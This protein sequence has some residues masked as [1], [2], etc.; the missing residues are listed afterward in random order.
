MIPTHDIHIKWSHPV[1]SGNAFIAGTWSVPGHGPW[2][3][4]PMTRIDGTDSF[5]IH[6]DVQE[7]EDISDYLDEDGYLHHEL[8]DHHH[9]GSSPPL[10]PTSTTSSTTTHLSRRKRLSRFFGRA[11]SP[12][13]AS[14][15]ST[16]STNNK[17]LHIDLP[18]HHQSKDGTVLPLAREYRYQYK[19]VIDDEWK[20]D[21]D[22]AQVQD[23]HGHWNHELVV[24]LVEQLPTGVVGGRSR[25][26]SLQ[27][28]HGPQVSEQAPINK[29]LPVPLPH[30]TITTTSI[31]DSITAI[32]TSIIVSLAE[33]QSEEL[34]REATE[35]VNTVSAPVPASSSTAFTAAAPAAAPAAA[36]VIP[37][38]T[39]TRRDNNV[40]S[41]DTYEAV[42]IFDETDDLSDGEGGHSKR[43]QVVESDDEDEEDMD[44][45]NNISIAIDSNNNNINNN[46][47]NATEANENVLLGEGEDVV[48]AEVTPQQ[49]NHASLSPADQQD[50]YPSK[51]TSSVVIKA[52]AANA[53]DVAAATPVLSSIEAEVSSDKA[54][55][56]AQQA[57]EEKKD[58]EQDVAAA[59][60]DVF[61][62]SSSVAESLPQLGEPSIIILAAPSS[63]VEAEKVA[64]VEKTLEAEE[65]PAPSS[66]VSS[67]PAPASVAIPA[68]PV[69]SFASVAAQSHLLSP[70]VEPETFALQAAVNLEEDDGEDNGDKSEVEEVEGLESF[71]SSDD[72]KPAVPAPPAPTKA[73]L[74]VVT[75]ASAIAAATASAAALANA[76]TTSNDYSQVPSPPL[77]PS[78]LTSSMRDLSTGQI[79]SAESTETESEK[80]QQQN[81]ETPERSVYMTP[82]SETTFIKHTTL[83][84]TTTSVEES[85]PLAVED[86]NA[87]ID[88]LDDNN[89]P[90]SLLSSSLSSSSLSTLTEG[91]SSSRRNSNSSASTK[92]SS[93]R[94][95]IVDYDKSNKN[96][97]EQYPNLLWSFCKTTAVVSAAVVILGL[98][99]G[100]RRD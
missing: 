21:H 17:D 28:Q 74:E 30:P 8:L 69:F 70:G 43:T 64:V 58:V 62:N 98:G 80:Q 10:T 41:R 96:G 40:K 89:L 82:R 86:E 20:C 49:D 24:E 53:A 19:F 85:L 54:I 57:V 16:T 5:E 94:R 78:N 88:I 11:R 52:S 99:L 73:V 26:S 15:A 45:S 84:E 65:T 47:E 14:T 83:E 27:S 39:T 44:N 56:V 42:L 55:E 18:Y 76:T 72:V 3:K 36:A 23:P 1:P 97:S 25:S 75:D 91:Q 51:D 90:A 46:S 37:S 2:E 61:V 95:E 34:E 87:T 12:S 100:R 9:Q 29:P 7:I 66:V 59:I 13:S 63:T 22:R 68:S 33:E 48:K 67:C 79:I 31:S 32:P 77:T 4:L 60:E 93:L 81:D 35:N 50:N 6:L 92:A 71:P 38:S